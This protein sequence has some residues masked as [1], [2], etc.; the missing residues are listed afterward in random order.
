MRRLRHIPLFAYLLFLYNAV[1]FANTVVSDFALGTEILALSLPS[2]PVFTINIGESLL[3]VGV[4]ALFVEIF[5]T[6]QGGAVSTWDHLLA[7]LTWVGFVVE[8]VLVAKAATAIFA[9]LMLMALLEVIA[10]F[11]VSSKEGRRGVGVLAEP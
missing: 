7:V 9:T 5:K 11:T 3:M 2:G 8:F 1:V 6:T 10:G 4:V